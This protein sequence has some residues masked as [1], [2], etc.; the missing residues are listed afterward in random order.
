[1]RIEIKPAQ[2]KLLHYLNNGFPW[3]RGVRNGRQRAGRI[4]TLRCLVARQMV[5]PA[6]PYYIVTERGRIILEIFG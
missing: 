4:N 2:L 3:D 5:M 1:M 6:G